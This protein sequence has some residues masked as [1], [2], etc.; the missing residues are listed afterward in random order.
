MNASSTHDTKRSED[1][2]ARINVLSE[3]PAEW[4]RRLRRWARLNPSETAPD[5]N[6]QTLIYQSMLGAW[7]IEPDRL[8][9]YVTKALREGKTHSSWIDVNEEYESAVLSFVDSLYANEE[10]LKDFT[11]FQKKIAYSGALS[12]LSQLVLKITSPGVPDFYRGTDMWDFSLA[13]PDNRRPVDFASRMQTLS[14]LQK[15]VRPKELLKN[16]SDGRLKMYVTWKLLHFRRDHPGLF[17]EGE[18]IPLRVT[19]TKANHV[20]AFARH[21]HDEW[22]IVAVPR[23]CASLKDWQDT[24]IELPPDVPSRWT[25]VLTNEDMPAPFF[26]SRLFSTLPITAGFLEG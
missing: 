1:V 4:S 3:M 6:E 16:W 7:P 24:Q 17:R 2:R 21:L 11:R 23:L 18:Y 15:R 26:A 25:N 10:F 9:Q 13:D 14:E 5:R 20:I 22:C 8:K 12:S 19:G